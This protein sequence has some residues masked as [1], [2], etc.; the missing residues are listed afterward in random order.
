MTKQGTMRTRN[1]KTPVKTPPPTKKGPKTPVKAEPQASTE[2]KPVVVDLTAAIATEPGTKLESTKLEVSAKGEKEETTVNEK[3]SLEA[4]NEIKKEEDAKSKITSPSSAKKQ[5]KGASV[6]PLVKDEK[7]LEEKVGESKEIVTEITTTV[8]EVI[9]ELVVEQPKGMEVENVGEDEEMEENGEDDAGEDEDEAEAEDEGEEAVEDEEGNE[10]EAEDEENEGEE[11]EEEEGEEEEG[12]GEEVEGEAVADVL[13]ELQAPKL[14]AE[15][16][17][18]K[19]LEVF[20]GGLDKEAS[21][22]DVK[23]AFESIGEVIEVRLRKNLKTGRNKGY[24]FV[25]FASAEQA[26]RAYTELERTEIRG[27]SC[28][29]VP[30]EDNN[31]LFVGNLNKSWGKEQIGEKL[32]EYGIVGI[33][34]LTLMEDPQ[35]EGVNR[36]FAFIELA[37]HNDA[38]KA[39][40][41][42]AK[43]DALFGSDR[44]AKV[45]WAQQN[46]PDEVVMSQVKSVFVDG[47]PTVWGEDKVKEH[48][49]KYGEIERIV[50]ARN[51]SRS[52]RNDFAFV[53]FAQR[54]AAVACIDALKDSEVVD[55]ENKIKVKVKLAQPRPK[56]KAA[57]GG[58]RGGYPV[59]GGAQPGK[60]KGSNSRKSGRGGRGVTRGGERSL[61]R[62]KADPGVHKLLRV[63]KNRSTGDDRTLPIERSRGRRLSGALARLPR[64]PPRGGYSR[65][66]DLHNFRASRPNYDYRLPPRYDPQDDYPP[67]RSGGFLP[68]GLPGRRSSQLPLPPRDDGYLRRVGH[69]YGYEREM[70]VGLSRVRAPAPGMK[71]AYSTLDDA[72]YYDGARGYPRARIDY[73]D[74]APSQYESMR[75]P[76]GHS[77]VGAAGRAPLPPLTG[78][79]GPTGAS[80]LYGSGNLGYGSSLSGVGDYIP[81]GMDVRGSSLY[82]GS[83][84]YNY[85]GAGGSAS[86]Y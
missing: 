57:K 47:I 70:G 21:E 60:G 69:G 31:V 30:S 82:T 36:G 16:Q 79:L 6:K 61:G 20:I 34:E 41:R 77:T 27:K 15:R 19:R 11:E 48:F 45:A 7:V 29:V 81:S 78:S 22:D 1:T 53:N 23:K 59:G 55:G 54:D 50:L 62:A 13:P 14:V 17:K 40:K 38:L 65:R 64:I 49:G 66:E 84:G 25:R 43:P 42:L 71:R 68:Q 28:H 85:P 46:E 18:G 35:N 86:Y 4:N 3:S 67:P 2:E 74:V 56:S 24:A 5:K 44:S 39:L 32:K 76:V 83:S 51:M 75:V 72:S 9:E 73:E 63:L 37:T 33:E 80:S 58:V 26:T 12:E 52:K 10:D 8:T